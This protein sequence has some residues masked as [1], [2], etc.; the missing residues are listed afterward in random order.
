MTNPINLDDD[1]RV[2]Q[3][4]LAKGQLAKAAIAETL[5]TLPDLKDQAEW[6]DPSREDESEAAPEEDADEA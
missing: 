5:S 6:L 4:R 2:M 3:R 1:T